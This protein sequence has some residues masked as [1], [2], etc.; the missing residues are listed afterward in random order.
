[1]TSW[2]EYPGTFGLSLPTFSGLVSQVIIGSRP[3]A[4]ERCT[5][6]ALKS[7]SKPWKNPTMFEALPTCC[8]T[9]SYSAQLKGACAV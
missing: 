5:A 3:F 1:M 2:F 7:W 9:S 8:W 4:H 6:L